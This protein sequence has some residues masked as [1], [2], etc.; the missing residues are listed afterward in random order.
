MQT[1]PVEFDFM[2][3]FWRLFDQFGQ[4]RFGLARR[5]PMNDR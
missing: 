3:S 4:L 5:P 2:Q 1:V